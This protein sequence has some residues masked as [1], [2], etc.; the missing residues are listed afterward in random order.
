[1]FP[2]GMSSNARRWALVIGALIAFALPKQVECGYP[3]A[4]CAKAVGK[5]VCTRSELEPWGFYLIESVVGR[6]VGFAYSTTDDCR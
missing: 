2:P 6:D 3:G 5:E 4:R 1:V